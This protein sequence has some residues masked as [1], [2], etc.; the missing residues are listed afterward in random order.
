MSSDV[1][2]LLHRSARTP[3]EPV[4]AEAI[5]ARGR[6]RRLGSRA[7]AVGVTAL[8]LVGGLLSVGQLAGGDT[9]APYID[10]VPPTPT[11]VPASEPDGATQSGRSGVA[12][13]GRVVAVARDAPPAGGGGT[14][15]LLAPDGSGSEIRLTTPTPSAVTWFPDDRGGVVWQADGPSS[16]RRATS[17][18]ETT[19]LAGADAEGLAYRLVGVQD[20]GDRVLVERRRGT[21]P[22]EATSDLLGVPVDGGAPEVVAAAVGGWESALTHA[23]ALE[24]A[25][26]ALDVEA[27]QHTVV[28]P[29]DGDP[30]TVF[31]GGD[32]TGEYVRGMALGPGSD[33]F[34]LV[35]SA[36]GHP[37]RPDARLLRIDLADPHVTAEIDVPLQ[38]GIG[39]RWAVPSDVSVADGHLL[40]NRDAEGEWLRP[41]V[42]DLATGA[43]S[44]LDVVGRARLGPPPPPTAAPRPAC[45]T[46]DADLADAEPTGD[47]LYVYLP[48]T[49]ET[50][51]GVTYRLDTGERRSGEVEADVRRA[52]GRLLTAPDPSL[53]D[54]GY[55]AFD[56]A[57]IELR[58]V[59]LGGDGSLV[60]DF[61]FPDDGVGTLSTSHGGM[62][63][64]ASLLATLLQF[65][66]VTT[67]ELREGGRCEAY[68][69]FFEG[70]GCWRFDAG[71]APWRT[72]D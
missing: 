27:S 54:R 10:R 14:V 19:L 17:D 26:Y 72:S 53:R 67:V 25:L 45:A 35:E 71:E 46:E 6:R 42:L 61:T 62:V 47:R 63:W 29:P 56:R 66:Q 60:V 3:T 50:G 38:H 5:H 57:G 44:E 8:A 40:V 9:P 34:V 65:E 51:A 70:G 36:A 33:G 39:D 1:R 18:G 55:A 37:D 23:A 28:D 21:S 32:A 2:E 16:I 11:P 30:V 13:L 12:D 43:W 59:A 7:G 22:T 41:L 4:D 64:H 15:V 52:I 68:P 31:R 58:G 48:C 24:G 49:G 20:G 69:P